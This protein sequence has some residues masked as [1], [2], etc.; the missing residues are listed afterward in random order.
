[1][2]KPNFE[3]LFVSSYKEL[4]NLRGLIMMGILAGLCVALNLFKIT[5]LPEL[6]IRWSF[7][8]MAMCGFLFG[9]VSTGMVGIVVDLASFMMT[10]QRF[11]F[12]PGYTLSAFFGGIIYGLFLYNAKTNNLLFFII[13]IA[14][15]KFCINLFLNVLLSSYW[16]TFF[17]EK[18]FWWRVGVSL[19]KNLISLLFEIP[20]MFGILYGIA[21]LDEKHNLLK[22]LK[23]S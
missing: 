10:P 8:A 7:I 17:S 13:R 12:F 23:K 4:K 15:C 16:F 22:I 19:P 6:E 5:I 9:P 14:V 20:L 18:T 2:T 21:Y 1:M 11:P 3:N